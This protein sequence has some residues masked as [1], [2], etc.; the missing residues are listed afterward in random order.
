M[1]GKIKGI[2]VAIGG[3]TSGLTKAIDDVDSSLR[4]TQNE[5]RSVEN[6][7]KLDPNNVTLVK[8]KQDLL[9]QSISDTEKKLKLLKDNQEKVKK[10]FANNAEYQKAYQ[11]L[12]K[13]LDETKSRL[14]KLNKKEEETKK[15]F[16]SGQISAQKYEK[17]QKSL[18]DTRKKYSEL[19]KAKSDLE[20]SFKDGHIDES[21]YRA[22]QRELETTEKKLSDLKSEK[23]NI[24]VIGTEF[25][26]VKEKVTPV[27]SKI[28]KIGTTIGGVTTKTAKFTAALAKIDGKMISAAADGFK[29]YS[30]AVGAAT[31]A[32]TGY[33]INVGSDFESQMSTVQS[34]SGATGSELENLTAKAKE[35]GQT[36]QFSATEAAQGMEY[37]AMAGWSTADI[38]EGLAGIMNLA[39]ASGED[40]ATTSDIV[41][42]AMTAFGMSASE[43][44]RFADVL[45]KTA[46]SANTDVSTMGETFKNVAPL[47]GAMGYEIEDMSVAIGL[48]A[49]AGVK[50]SNAGTSLKNIITNLADPTDE[51]S[52]AMNEL[53]VSLVDSQGN[54]KS[55]ET[56]V[57]ELRESFNGLTESEKAQYASTI[58]GKQ[59]M[60]GMLA[61]VNS[62]DED[63]KSLAE[64][65]NNCNGAAEEMAA[66]RIDN[67]KGDVTLLKSNVESAAISL[68]E[69]LSPGLR[70]SV[71]GVND[72]VTAFNE[73]GV[74]GLIER[75]PTVIG[76]MLNS[77]SGS[78][79]TRAPEILTAINTVLSTLITTL[80]E[81]APGLINSILP[82]LLTGFFG[83]IQA[84]VD[85]VPTLVPTLADGAIT[86]FLGL[87]DG[88]NAVIEQLMPMLPDLITKIS[89]TLVENLPT[90]IEGGFQLLIG[91]IS[92]IA[93]CT[94]ELIDAIVD[95]I[96]V[97]TQAFT[98]NL[99][100][101]V[102]AGISLL[103]AV[104]EGLPKALPTLI[105]AIPDIFKA[106]VG[107]FA[108]QDW[109]SI[110]EDVLGGIIEGLK[111][112]IPAALE[113]V[114]DIGGSIVDGFC[115]FFDINSPSKVMAKRVGQYLP[116]GIGAG[117]ET[118]ADEPVKKAQSI[119]N[120]VAGV[121]ADM[122]PI[123]IQR[124]L[125]N[126]Y[127]LPSTTTKSQLQSTAESSQN[128][129]I[130]LHLVDNAGMLLAKAVAD[131]LDIINGQRIAF[132]DRG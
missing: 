25:S 124:K 72:L 69:D 35:L 26:S 89:D 41:T 79:Q 97:I 50:G 54:T 74:D 40:L 94:P 47:A 52:N 49:N 34:I 77:L 28:E 71:Q 5:L 80:A 8:Q 73:G 120:D 43:S 126:S 14:D 51:V 107:A 129:I 113:A 128:G 110:G 101:L 85:T 58:A 84:L 81:Q 122:N 1:A 61:L 9:N 48:M 104:A 15:A 13:Q 10:A 38:T 68:Y 83:L 105:G 70:E 116:P 30:T 75:M 57:G 12:K 3:D 21:Q 100:A 56:V 118:T 92:G 36:T 114:V 98:D 86:L 2:T 4:K 23:K 130:V 115:E 65:I 11:P 64:S 119:V 33:A 24:S 39:A 103:V 131:P 44:N 123:T 63:Y 88:L 62:S 32:T 76:G 112:A 45:A 99:P 20:K 109:L 132:E 31:A 127:S 60:S 117:M 111:S 29:K 6:A 42:D 108:E 27:I 67:L 82:A 18:E 125:N 55:F 53:G 7:L 90:I 78:L 106:V 37:M 96:P 19:Q 66:V 87:L 102:E 93:N 16:E 91:L 22:F 17:F 46:G 59:G 95:L 121:T